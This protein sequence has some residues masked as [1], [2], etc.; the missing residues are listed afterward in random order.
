LIFHTQTAD[1]QSIELFYPLKSVPIFEQES[2]DTANCI[3]V[4]TITG[5][6]MPGQGYHEK[7]FLQTTYLPSS[8][9]FSSLLNYISNYIKRLAS[10]F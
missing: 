3:I 5:G 8:V 9:L 10:L 6:F 2:L 4:N 1:V 7:F